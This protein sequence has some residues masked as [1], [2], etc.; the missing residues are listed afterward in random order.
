MAFVCR[1]F[2]KKRY[3]KKLALKIGEYVTEYQ[4]I[5]EH[6]KLTN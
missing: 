6:G 4:N 5:L 1:Y 2:A 3:K